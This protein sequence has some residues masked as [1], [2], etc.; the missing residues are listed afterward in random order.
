MNKSVFALILLA[1]LSSQAAQVPVFK[2]TVPGKVSSVTVDVAV[3]DSEAV[4][5]VTVDLNDKGASK[6][7]M[8]NAKGSFQKQ[9]DAGS[10]TTLVLGDQYSQG[11]DG[12]IR[13]AGIL[14][15]GLENGKWTGIL[16]VND[17]VYP[18]DCTKL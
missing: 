5:Y 15:L 11:D 17:A 6:L 7:F 12:V 10:V 14:G 4:D 3:S 8:Q 2:C 13:D 18:L 1:G 16:S 9:V